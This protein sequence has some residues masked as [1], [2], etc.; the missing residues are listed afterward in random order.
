[1]MLKAKFKVFLILG[2]AC[3]SSAYSISAL[4]YNKSSHKPLLPEHRIV[5]YYGNFYSPRMG[6]LGE[7]SEDEVLGRLQ[8]EVHHWNEADSDSPVVPAIEYIAVVAQGSPGN[9]GMHRA[10]MP[11]DQIQ[12]AI[13]MADKINGIVILDV[14]VGFSDVEKEI[15][16]LAKFLALPNV[17]LALDPEFSMKG[18]NPPGTVIGTMDAH[19]INY[20][21]DYL[22]HLVKE[23][24]LPPKV[25]I[26]HRFTQ[27]MVTHAPEIHPTSEVQVVMDM[28]GWG[29]KQL[30]LSSYR[31]FIVPEPV[32]YT[33]FKLFYKND[34][35]NGGSL[36]SPAEILKFNPVPMFIMYQ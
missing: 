11:D 33:G 12:K 19:D 6:I 23:N 36:Y 16:R 29:D 4:A 8:D 26:V 21:V 17:M 28:D 30:K 18:D 27:R 32:E 3:L 7:Y 1:M 2:F 13:D 34:T 31:S 22:S 10:R 15:P 9:D 35:K 20:V 14:Q 25:L 24:D 5:A